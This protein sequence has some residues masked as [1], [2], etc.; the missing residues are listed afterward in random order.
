MSFFPSRS[1]F[2]CPLNFCAGFCCAALALSGPLS[3]QVPAPAAPP[4][5]LRFELPTSGLDW[6]APVHPLKFFD[7]TG[8][9]AGVFG[10][11]TGQYEAWIY[12][13]KVLH[14]LRLEFRQEGMPEPVRG[15]NYLEYLIVRPESTT[16][17]YVHPRFTVRQ[18][19]W[20]PLDE[21]A[22][23]NFFEVDSDKPLAITVKFVP[24]FKPMWPASLGGQYAY[25]MAEEKAFG[26]T[27]GTSKPTAVVGSPSVGAFTEHMDH[28]MVG[29]EMLLQLRVEHDAEKTPREMNLTLA[30]LGGRTYTL[31]LVTTVP[32]LT[33]E[34]ATVKNTENGYRLEI[35]FEGPENEYVTRQI[36][37]RW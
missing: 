16:L 30:G 14:G 3:A 24:D 13:I 12:P 4:G 9:R 28:S 32:N 35:S 31:D 27:D 33:A 2:R 1:L 10:K 22:I 37:L 11:Q 17:V 7:A 26:I 5:I 25:W 34:G 20:T 8:H 29:G 21:P 23:V 6:K 36:R 15:E 19:I 18:I